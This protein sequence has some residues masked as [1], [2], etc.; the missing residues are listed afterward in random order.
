[1]KLSSRETEIIDLISWGF[2]D[3]EIALKLFISPRTVQTH[4][5]RIVLKL[6]ARN[7]T[8]AVFKYLKQSIA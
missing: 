6:D 2:S 4:V 3:K 5:T 7:R 1:M 8:N